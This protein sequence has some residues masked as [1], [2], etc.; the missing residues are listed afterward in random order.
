MEKDGIPLSFE[1]NAMNRG[2]KNEIPVIS[3]PLLKKAQIDKIR[4]NNQLDGEKFQFAYGFDVDINI[5]NEST[6]DSLKNGTL[7]R[8][9]IKSSGAKSLNLIFGNYELP[10]GA[11]LFIYNRDYRTL[12]GS[13]TIENNKLSK[14]LA[15]EP[16]S[17]EEI[18]VEYFEPYSNANSSN[19]LVISK[20]SHDIYGIEDADFGNSGN[21]QVDINCNEGCMA[22]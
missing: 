3:M 5:K 2:L 19:N 9:N 20:V 17:G 14:K 1:L 4:T 11:S 16:L 6:A 8:V 13:F 15:V 7:Y 21:C 12:R 18:T 22:R 10:K